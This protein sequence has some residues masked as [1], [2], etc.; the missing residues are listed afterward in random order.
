MTNSISRLIKNGVPVHWVSYRALMS[1]AVCIMYIAQF[2]SMSGV[3]LARELARAGDC[4]GLA[5]I[6]YLVN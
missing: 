4:V 2:E 6:M 1:F 5:R 3:G